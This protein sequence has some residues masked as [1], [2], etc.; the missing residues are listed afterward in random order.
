[1]DGGVIL[2]VGVR[3]VIL[4]EVAEEEGILFSVVVEELVMVVTPGWNWGSISA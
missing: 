3:E 2:E 1:M 4:L